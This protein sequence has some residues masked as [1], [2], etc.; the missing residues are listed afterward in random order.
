[1]AHTG[2]ATP[3]VVCASQ[4]Y[5][6]QA[7]AFS[8]GL[9][10]Q[11]GL[12][13]CAFPRSKPFRFS[14]AL[15]GHRPGWAR[16]FV[17]SPGPS[18]SGDW[19]LGKCTIS[20]GPCIFI[21]SPVPATQFPRCSMR[22]SSQAW[23]V[24]PLGSWSQAVTL[25]AGVNHPGFQKDVVSNWESAPSLVEVPSLWPRLQKPLAFWLWLSQ[26]CLSAS[27]V[28]AGGGALYASS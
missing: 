26:A 28:G 10:S 23:C 5:T 6:G 9:L 15:Q 24:S 8:E 27:G 25:L 18:G 12:A 3:K 11:V 19:V 14:G 16:H 4:V 7:P 1:M 17:P 22:A 2:F 21:T 20:G 13:F